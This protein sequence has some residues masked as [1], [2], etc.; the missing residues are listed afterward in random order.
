M[1]MVGFEPTT[2]HRHEKSPSSGRDHDLFSRRA[3][4]RWFANTLSNSL[5]HQAQ[6]EEV[7]Q[8]ECNGIEP[9]THIIPQAVL[10]VS[11]TWQPNKALETR[12]KGE[13][14]YPR[15]ITGSV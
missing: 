10:C 9:S 1:D 2:I 5:C 11:A 14:T 8:M 6:M 4:W 3:T 12:L 7:L 15:G 13:F